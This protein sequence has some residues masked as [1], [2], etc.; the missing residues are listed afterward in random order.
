M[1]TDLEEMP[2]M[3]TDIKKETAVLQDQPMQSKRDNNSKKKKEN[4]KYWLNIPFPNRFK[5]YMRKQ[6]LFNAR[7]DLKQMPYLNMVQWH[8]V[9]ISSSLSAE[10]MT[11][12]FAINS[13]PQHSDTTLCCYLPVNC[14][15]SASLFSCKLLS[16]GFKVINDREKK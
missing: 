9:P 12:I 13:F 1:V 10:L 5:F 3:Q 6:E 7:F 15:F 11:L 16:I 4:R 14:Q 2:T 8:T